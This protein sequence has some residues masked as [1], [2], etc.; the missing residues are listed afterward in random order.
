MIQYQGGAISRLYEG[1][2]R[3]THFHFPVANFL[4]DICKLEKNNDKN[5]TEIQENIKSN[6]KNRK[7][8]RKHK[9]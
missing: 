5:P 8:I 3:V 6:K 4:Y 1:G 7:G 9:R 2:S